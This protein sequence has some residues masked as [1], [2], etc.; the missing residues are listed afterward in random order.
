[1][2]N[3]KA[4][5]D[6]RTTDHRT[7]GQRKKEETT[8]PLTTGLRTRTEETTGP[9]TTGPR[10]TGPQTAEDGACKFRVQRSAYNVSSFIAHAVPSESGPLCPRPDEQTHA[11]DLAVRHALVGL[12]AFAAVCCS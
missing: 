8:G 5:K 10:T 3:R 9:R 1:M 7:T 4:R 2:K 12:L 6:H 11:R